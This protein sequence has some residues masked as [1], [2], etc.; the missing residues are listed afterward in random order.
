[1][2]GKALQGLRVLELGSLIG[3]PFCATLMAEFGADV[4]KVEDPEVGDMSR[5]LGQAVDGTGLMFASLGRNKRCATL[6]LRRPEGQDLLLRL[7]TRCD[8]VV[9]NFR[10]GTLAAWNLDWARLSA[11]NPRLVLAHV[12]GFGQTGP[13]RD[14]LAFDRIAT[15]FSGQD[16]VTGFPEQPPT[17]PGGALADYITAL[18]CTIGVMF[19]L[20]HRDHVS[21]RGQEIDLALYEGIL[22]I[23]GAIEAYDLLGTVPMRAGNANPSIAPA[24]TFATRDGRWVAINGGTD[25][26]W[27]RLLKLMGREDLASDARFASARERARHHAE[28]NAIVGAWV[29][30]QDAE[31]LLDALERESVPATRV[32]T[33]ADAV[34]DPHVRARGNVV[35]AVLESGRAFLT[36]GVVPKLSESPGAID[37]VAPPL[38]AHNEAVWCGL[39]GLSAGELEGLRVAG[40]V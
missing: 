36:T 11:A 1:M 26:V 15:A 33:I 28:V 2:G 10:P 5:H 8:V 23:G 39:V 27:R 17:R 37:F 29:A 16:H 3:A 18:F 22:R 6:D 31:P 25:N 9:E 30:G 38:G 21:G 14:R 34:A 40:V 20:H 24:E 12:S 35:Q 13:Y 19:A 32:N 7:A 4:I